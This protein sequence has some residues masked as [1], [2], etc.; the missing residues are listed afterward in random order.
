MTTVLLPDVNVLLAG[1]PHTDHV[2]LDQR[3][4]PEAARSL[5]VTLGISDVAL[6]S[7]VRLAANPRVFRAA[8]DRRGRARLH[9]RAAGFTASQRSSRRLPSAA[10][11]DEDACTVVIVQ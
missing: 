5:T 11:I 8:G 9:R 7:V 1:F 4:F 10:V 3:A 2:H 6:S